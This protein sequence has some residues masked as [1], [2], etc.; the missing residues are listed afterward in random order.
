MKKNLMAICLLLC[1]VA[2]LAGSP[3]KKITGKENLKPILRNEAEALIEFDWSNAKFDKT[4]DLKTQFAGDYDY[5]LNDCEQKF[6]EGFNEKTKKM[7]LVKNS[8][9]AKYKVVLK[10]SSVDH[11]Y[12]AMIFIPRFEAKMWGNLEIIDLTTNQP[13]VTVVID[14]AEE[15]YDFV[16]KDCYGKTFKELGENVA[17]LK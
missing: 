17:K 6:I 13:V 3:F 14:E 2:A 12:Q 4:K 10:V 8:S 11:Y 16:I 1:S 7:K 5:I 9:D 15:G